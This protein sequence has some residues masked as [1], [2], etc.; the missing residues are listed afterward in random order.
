M[1]ITYAQLRAEGVLE[2]GRIQSIVFAVTRRGL[3]LFHVDRIE[4]RPLD[5]YAISIATNML[6]SG[7]SDRETANALD[8]E[9][10]HLRRELKRAGYERKSLQ[11]GGPRRGAEFRVRGVM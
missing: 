5:A 4:H 7:Y 10:Q 11:D 1:T 8:V 3:R 9:V 6:E 2:V